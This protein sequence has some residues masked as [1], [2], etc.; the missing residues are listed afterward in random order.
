MKKQKT[1]EDE[2]GS[3]LNNNK[4]PNQFK[5]AIVAIFLLTYLF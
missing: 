3:Q 5:M 2:L 4:I 1:A